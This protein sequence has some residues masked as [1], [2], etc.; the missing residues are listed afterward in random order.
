MIINVLE[1]D[2]KRILTRCKYN[3]NTVNSEIK[4]N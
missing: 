3:I 1:F 4:I 2:R